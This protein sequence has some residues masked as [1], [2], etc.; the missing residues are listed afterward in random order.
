MYEGNNVQAMNLL[1]SLLV[2]GENGVQRD[3]PYALEL[4]SRAIDEGI[5]PDAMY[6]LASI[7]ATGNEQLEQDTPQSMQL[8]NWSSSEGDNVRAMNL[9]GILLVKAR[10]LCREIY[11]ALWG[12]SQEQ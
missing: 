7:L 10:M 8:L 2:K 6:N 11:L 4:F 12:F 9:L 5:Y 1:G 3:I